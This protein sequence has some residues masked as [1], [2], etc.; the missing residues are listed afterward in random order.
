MKIS[1][2]MPTYNIPT[3]LLA[4]AITSVFQQTHRDFEII[5]KDGCLSKP[6]VDAPYIQELIDGFGDK[7]KYI[8][9]PDG[10][11][12][13]ERKL[14]VFSGYYWALND[15]IKASTGDILSILCAD[16][17]RGGPDVLKHVNQE[18]EDHGP[19]PFLLYGLCEWIDRQGEHICYKQP[20]EIPVTFETILR[21]WPFYTP[22]L[23]WN[24]AV[25]DKFGLFDPENCPWTG[26]VEF[27]LRCWKGIDSKYTP[28]LIGQYRQW[29]T[30]HARDNGHYLGLEGSR[31]Q[32]QYREAV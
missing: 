1:I 24:R 23:F 20:P 15:C 11:P 14:G 4:I 30:S 10:P 25:H 16:D 17:R 8:L 12:E 21:D 18:F 22:S 32:K 26:D 7:I 3:E 31:I 19:N 29:E 6:A 9:S 2:L 27:W 28:E 5:I 13:S